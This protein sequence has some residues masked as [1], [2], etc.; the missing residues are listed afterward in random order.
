MITSSQPKVS[1][2]DS[3][4]GFQP[5]MQTW[6]LAVHN[7]CFL[8]WTTRTYCQEVFHKFRKECKKLC[9]VLAGIRI[10]LGNVLKLHEPRPFPT[11]FGSESLGVKFQLHNLALSYLGFL[12]CLLQETS[13]NGDFLMSSCW[14]YVKSGKCDTIPMTYS[15]SLQ[16]DSGVKPRLRASVLHS[17]TERVGIDTLEKLWNISGWQ[18][19][20]W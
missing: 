15:K 4:F 7:S 13:K 10:S 8:Q 9:L 16:S 12:S 1:E 17:C 5:A 20:S 2:E 18:A 3:S 19:H 6:Y 14:R 11:S